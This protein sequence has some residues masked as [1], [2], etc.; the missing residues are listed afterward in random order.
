M[1]EFR[2]S[3]VGPGGAG[4]RGI[5]SCLDGTFY[6]WS[7]DVWQFVRQR[8]YTIFISNNRASFNLWWN[9]NLVKHLNVSKYYE[10]YCIPNSLVGKG[11]YAKTWTSLE[12]FCPWL[13]EKFFSGFTSLNLSGTFSNDHFFSRKK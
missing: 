11:N 7:R 8:L 9:E 2:P 13:P 1:A 12:I 10:N 5:P 3:G 4:G 6:M